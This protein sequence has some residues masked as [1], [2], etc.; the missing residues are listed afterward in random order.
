LKRLKLWRKRRK[1]S[2]SYQDPLEITL[3][4]PSG[5]EVGKIFISPI[6]DATGRIESESFLKRLK[7]ASASGN[8]KSLCVVPDLHPVSPPWKRS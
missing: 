3:K 1:R 2:E 5:E 8:L 6:G 4:T 7:K